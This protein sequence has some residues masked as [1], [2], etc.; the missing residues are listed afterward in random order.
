ML[1]PCHSGK[2]YESCCKP[3]HDGA[4]P[5]NALSL[6]RSRFSAYA[7]QN[8]Q[9]IIRTT[10]P[11]NPHYKENHDQ[12]SKEI[13]DF[14]HNTQFQKLDILEVSDDGDLSYV[15]FNAHLLQDHQ[16]K[17]LIEKSSFAKIGKQWLYRD[18]ISIQI[19]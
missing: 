7:L 10:H 5:S 9:Y 16:E 6:M 12:W 11:D 17:Q 18:A 1:C 2:K 19:V 13:L 14:C 3:L 15:T 4:F 8:P